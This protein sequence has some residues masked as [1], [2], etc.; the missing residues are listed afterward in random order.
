MQV[1]QRRV[2]G[3]RVPVHGRVVRSDGVSDSVAVQLGQAI[4]QHDQ[5]HALVD[6][7]RRLR[8]KR[9]A[10]PSMLKPLR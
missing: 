6:D 8:L 9:V 2:A 1:R 10:T 3:E 7:G 4:L 5:R